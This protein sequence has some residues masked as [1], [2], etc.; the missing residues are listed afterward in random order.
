M[1]GALQL[2]LGL[3]FAVCG[4]AGSDLT[5]TVDGDGTC[6]TLFTAK[7][8]AT[9]V[10]GSCTANLFNGAT[11]GAYPG[12]LLLRA[13]NKVNAPVGK[14]VPPYF[15]T[16]L[17]KLGLGSIKEI[18][19][20]LHTWHT[21]MYV[22]CVLDRSLSFPGTSCRVLRSSCPG[23]QQQV[24]VT[25]ALKAA[26]KH[27]VSICVCTASCHMYMPDPFPP[28]GFVRSEGRNEG[29]LRDPQGDGTLAAFLSRTA[30]K[31]QQLVAFPHF[32]G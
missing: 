20:P 7:T 2:D 23:R 27:V 18:G 30:G 3:W 9:P 5:I 21:L 17:T 14:Y 32:G 16:P 1:G 31:F 6:S 10:S 8:G 12:H 11:C 29:I 25:M 13:V 28:A 22:H 4:D 19:K 26:A 15:Q 24:V